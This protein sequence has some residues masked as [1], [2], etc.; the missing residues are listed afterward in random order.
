ME[1]RPLL[2]TLARPREALFL[3]CSPWY[4]AFAFAFSVLCAPTSAR[5]LRQTMAARASVAARSTTT[6]ISTL[7]LTVAIPFENAL[8]DRLGELLAAWEALDR[9]RL[10]TQ[11]DQAGAHV[12]LRSPR[13]AGRG[14]HDGPGDGQRAA[15]G[16]ARQAFCENAEVK[17]RGLALSVACVQMAQ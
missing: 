17:V 3:R 16:S 11:V 2:R 13:R 14:W 4:I 1:A 8:C 9:R 7:A 10:W 15:R 6:A 12:G 5:D